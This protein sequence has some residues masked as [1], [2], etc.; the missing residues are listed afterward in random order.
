M[1]FQMDTN[2][3]P[4]DLQTESLCVIYTRKECSKG[5]ILIPQICAYRPNTSQFNKLSWY[6]CHKT[7]ISPVAWCQCE[8]SDRTPRENITRQ[9]RWFHKIVVR[10]KLGPHNGKVTE[11]WRKFYNYLFF[12]PHNW[13]RNWHSVQLESETS[14]VHTEF[15]SEISG[16]KWPFE[17]TRR[18]WED[19][20]NTELTV[21][22]CALDWK[23]RNA[24]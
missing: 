11:V 13:R 17:V 1:K 2:C 19:G 3:V 4:C 7:I 15:W 20:N 8:A 12:S 16:K 24:E 6:E 10:R 21:E 18:R 9:M 22:Q 5:I 14:E 23:C